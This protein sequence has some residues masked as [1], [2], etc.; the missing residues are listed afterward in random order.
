MWFLFKKMILTNGNLAKR[1]L[2]GC[3][4]CVFCVSEETIDHFFISCLFSL[5]VWRVVHFTFNIPP[6]INITHL[7]DN[8]LNEIDKKIKERIRV[9]VCT[10]V[11]TILNCCN[12]VIFNRCT[13]PK[14]LQVIHRTAFLIHMWSYLFPAEQRI[15][16]DGG[17]SGYNQPAW[18]V[19]LWAH[20]RCPVHIT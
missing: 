14:F 20:W 1:Q 6:P 2:T 19:A 11:W 3:T 12:K 4:K 18:L 17:C 5:L 13:N 8:W 7:F 16:L 9:R 10:I 15:P